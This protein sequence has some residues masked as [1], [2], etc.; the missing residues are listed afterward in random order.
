MD[1]WMDNLDS[2]QFNDSILVSRT[3]AYHLRFFDAVRD[4]C[5]MYTMCGIHR[6][7][8]G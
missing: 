4:A 5:E 1:G 3:S 8:D 2:S 6:G 7:I